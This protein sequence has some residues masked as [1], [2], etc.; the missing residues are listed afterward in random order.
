MTNNR[1]HDDNNNDNDDYII[2]L[3]VFVKDVCI[4]VCLCECVREY[5]SLQQCTD[6]G[7]H[8]CL[9]MYECICSKV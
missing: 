4:S 8:K 7:L 5:C 2:W 6:V 1:V 3:C 9:C